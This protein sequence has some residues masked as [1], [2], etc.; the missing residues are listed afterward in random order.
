M[1][2]YKGNMSSSVSFGLNNA[3][4]IEEGKRENRQGE[5][6]REREGI[7]EEGRAGESKKEKL[8]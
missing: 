8:K 4:E 3:V 6:G 7:G 5:W 2:K 1:F